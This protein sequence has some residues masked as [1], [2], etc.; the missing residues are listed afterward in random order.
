MK[1]Y[2]FCLIMAILFWIAVKLTPPDQTLELFTGWIIGVGFLTFAL[3][4]VIFGE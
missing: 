4:S 2:Q 1:N 3:V